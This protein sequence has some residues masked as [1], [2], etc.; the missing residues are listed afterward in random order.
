M[1]TNNIN[2]ANKLNNNKICKTMKKVKT[3]KCSICGQKIEGFSHNAYPV[4]N[5]R[6][7]DLCNYKIVLP[8]RVASEDLSA[9]K[10]RGENEVIEFTS[11]RFKGVAFDYVKSL[12]VLTDYKGIFIR[13]FPA[14]ELDNAVQFF[15]DIYCSFTSL[16]CDYSN[17]G[18]HMEQLFEKDL[19]DALNFEEDIEDED[20]EDNE[21]ELSNVNFE[22]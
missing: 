9:I 15:E 14:D 12:Q 10:E 11:K 20:I 7:C 19:L 16:I 22:L 21:F 18:K 1:R 8:S 3:Q 17:V 5:G 13:N 4:T 6:C 2:K